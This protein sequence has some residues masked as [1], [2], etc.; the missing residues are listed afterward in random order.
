MKKTSIN[1]APDR[2]VVRD[3]ANTSDGG[4]PQV[5]GFDTGRENRPGKIYAA[6]EDR[7]GDGNVSA[8]MTEF[9]NGL[10]ETWEKQG[11]LMANDSRFVEAHYSEP[12]TQYSVGWRD[13]NN[14]EATLEF[15]APKVSTARRFEFA[16][17]TNVE[18]FLT[19]VDDVREIMG[20]FKRVQYSSRKITTRTLNKGLTM[21]VDLDQ[22]GETVQNWREMYTGRLMRRLL[23]NELIRGITA[24]SA[25][26]TGSLAVT[27]T[28]SAL[29][30]QD[31]DKDIRNLADVVCDTIGIQPNRALY[32]R[33]A[34]TWR[35]NTYGNMNAPAGYTGYAGAA[36]AAMAQ[37]GVSDSIGV[38]E[39]LISNER[40]TTA[41]TTKSQAVGALV[42]CYLAEPNM[43]PEDPS[44]IKRFVSPTAGGTPF[45]VFEHQTGNPHLIDITVEHY[46]Q[47][48]VTAVNGIGKA[49]ITTG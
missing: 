38:D 1:K 35:R 36:Y 14:I 3:F 18:E 12:L 29:S 19:E 26:P 6:S 4:V 2:I 39:I 11:R 15:V 34:W 41:P 49:T 30:A 46:S 45:R 42:L 28:W 17:F 22:V 48:V 5:V 7:Y 8:K 21:R 43:T 24:L 25:A 13:P 31:P 40:I 27:P 47:I 10:Y 16:A 44:A 9:A 23:R 20:E 37:Q 32:G 33:K